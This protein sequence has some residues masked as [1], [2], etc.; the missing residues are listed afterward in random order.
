[1][2][3]TN[4]LEALPRYV[5]GIIAVV[6]VLALFLIGHLYFQYGKISQ[7]ER[8]LTARHLPAIIAL[9]VIGHELNEVEKN[10]I[11]T[12]LS[13]LLQAAETGVQ[14]PGDVNRDQ[15]SGHLHLINTRVRAIQDR[16]RDKPD[17]VFVSSTRQLQSSIHR[18]ESSLEEAKGANSDADGRV[19]TAALMHA[20]NLVEQLSRLHLKESAKIGDE[21]LQ[22]EQSSARN[23]GGTVVLA[24]LIGGVVVGRLAFLLR[25]SLASKRESDSKLHQY[26]DNLEGLVAER[27]R[28]L[29]ASNREL[30][31]YSYSIAHDLRTPLRAVTSFSQILQED[32]GAKLDEDE[33]Q[34]LERVIRAG[35]YMAR[36]IDD[37]LELSR[38]SR[39]RLEA[40]RFD[41]SRLARDIASRLDMA[42][43]DRHVE[44]RIQDGLKVR[45]SRLL[46][47]VSLD[48]LFSNAWK[49]TEK[50]DPACIE[51]GATRQNGEIVYFVKDNGVGFDMQY[52]DKLFK[53]FQRLHSQEDYP[54]TGVGLATVERVIRRH[55]GSIWAES[56]E[57]R[58]ATFLFSLPS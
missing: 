28:E 15:V 46:L 48:N 13:A 7:L 56:E 35:K 43:P 26:R 52:A 17:V 16:Q 47:E 34:S 10:I 27:S 22:M 54:G 25:S 37:I 49:Y 19:F 8:R 39:T 24:L 23:I 20:Q 21:L 14:Q 58:G 2:K 18:L 9:N 36:L 4:D 41:L 5:Y 55:G 30:E 42:Y 1:M 57:G 12:E 31:S 40:E 33:K 51:F 44:W 50:A 38:I 29:E 3:N 53:P 45:G 11:Q 6:T 32:A